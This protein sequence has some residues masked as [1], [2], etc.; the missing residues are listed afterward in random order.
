MKQTLFLATSIAAAGTLLVPG[1][2][3]AS[4]APARGT[5]ASADATSV[6]ATYEHGVA[7]NLGCDQQSSSENQP[8][9]CCNDQQWR[10]LH[11]QYCDQ[12]NTNDIPGLPFPGFG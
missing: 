12:F 2:A 1:V 7:Q 10:D 9:D 4:A 6:S 11:Q 8:G 3:Y 5:A